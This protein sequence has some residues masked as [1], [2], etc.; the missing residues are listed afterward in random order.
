MKRVKKTSKRGQAL[1]EYLILTALIGVAGIAVVQVLAKNLH[2]RFAEIASTLGGEKK[3]ISA[4]KIK[5]DQYK[6]HD[7]GNFSHGF[8][9][10]QKD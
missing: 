8:Q 1:S 4:E 3:K 6:I 7:L 5:E 10:S 2:S 9:D